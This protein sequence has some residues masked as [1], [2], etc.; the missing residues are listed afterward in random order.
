[1]TKNEW[2]N[3]SKDF[4]ECEFYGTDEMAM[5]IHIKK[6]H[7]EMIECG[8]CDSVFEDPEN[9]DHHFF[10]CE[11]YQCDKCEVHFK[12]LNNLK[13]H[14][15]ERHDGESTRIY[16]VKQNRKEKDE[17]SYSLHMSEEIF[18]NLKVKK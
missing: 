9:V 1:M 13:K 4:I 15:L 14:L 8:L 18:P 7:S 16:H 11:A 10:T 6:V 5:E 2:S 3:V 12:T 17:L